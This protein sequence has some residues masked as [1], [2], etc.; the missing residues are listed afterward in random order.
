MLFPAI[1]V[2]GPL[3]TI[4]TSAEEL[5]VVITVELSFDGFESALE[6]DAVAVLL[7][8]V[9]FAT[10][11]AACT[12][13]ELRAAAVRKQRDRAGDVAV[14]VR[15]RHVAVRRRAGVLHE[16]DE[17]DAGG[18]VVVE[19]G[20][21]RGVGAGIRQRDDVVERRAAGERRRG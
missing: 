20:V 16:G 8:I 7:T 6:V 10:V 5:T 17:V 4:D 9:P 11:G 21:A 12:V 15:R 13:G 3:F 1:T 19:R 14:G 2:A 18:E